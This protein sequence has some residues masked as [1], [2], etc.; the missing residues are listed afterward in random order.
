MYG[1]TTACVRT[2]VRACVPRAQ[3]SIQYKTAQTSVGSHFCAQCYSSSDR[4]VV[5]RLASESMWSVQEIVKTPKWEHRARPY[6]IPFGSLQTSVQTSSQNSSWSS[7][8][9]P[10]SSMA[11]SPTAVSPGGFASPGKSFNMSPQPTMTQHEAWP[12]QYPWMPSWPYYGPCPAPSMSRRHKAH[13]RTQ[14]SRNSWALKSWISCAHRLYHSKQKNNNTWAQ[15]VFKNWLLC[16]NASKDPT[17]EKFPVDILQTHYETIVVDRA[18]AAF[19]LEAMRM[20]GNYYPG[21]TIRNILS[22]IHKAN[23]GAVNVKSF[24]DKK[25]RER[26]YPQLNSGLDRQLRMLRMNGIGVERKCA[27]VIT[28]AIEQQLWIKGI[29][30]LH[31]PLSLLN[32]VFFFTMGRTSV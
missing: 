1:K 17:I 29:L 26:F 4:Y 31:S 2:R 32:T 19:V 24:I 10:C 20:D 3:S 14:D 13:S 23:L 5:C 16:R 11:M 12:H 6:R 7:F 21:T 27:Q 15:G 28:P 30:G 22:A 25:E 9:S 8:Y 18:L